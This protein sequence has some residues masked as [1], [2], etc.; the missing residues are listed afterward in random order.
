MPHGVVVWGHKSPKVS[1]L[2]TRLTV[3]TFNPLQLENKAA[4][5][6]AHP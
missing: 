4:E 5:S 2:M 6:S 1:E 3:E